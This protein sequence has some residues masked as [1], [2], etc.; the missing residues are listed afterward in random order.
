MSI[1]A[2]SAA[3]ADGNNDTIVSSADAGTLALAND[4]DAIDDL[5]GNYSDS[6]G[7]AV[8][9]DAKSVAAGKN[10]GNDLLSADND[11][12][13]NILTAAPKTYYV[14]ASAASGG[15]GTET[16]P[17]QTLNAALNKA[18]NGDTIMIAA[19]EYKGTDNTGLSI[20]RNLNFIK[21]GESEAIF[22]AEG[23]RRIWT[24]MDDSINI[25]GLTFKNGI[26][27]EGGAIY[28][29]G[30]NVT[31]CTFTGNNATGDS[32]SAGGAIYCLFYTNVTNCNFTGNTAQYRGGA[33]YFMRGGNVSD[34]TFT[35]NTANWWGGAIRLETAD[36]TKGTVINCA[37][38]NN[39]AQ[40]GKVISSSGVLE[41][42][43]NN[44][45]GSND[46]DWNELIN[47]GGIPSTYAVLNGSA[48]SETIKPG[49]NAK[50]NYTFYMNG[51]ANVLSIPSR[52]I[53]LSATG[54]HLDDDTGYL[55]N[56]E[57]STEFSSDALGEFEITATV[58]NQEVKLTETVAATVWYVNATAA[59]GGDGKSQA[60]PFQ[61]L[62]EALDVAEDY[63]TIMIAAGTYT[64]T[65]NIGLSINKKLSF[66]KYGAGEAIFDAQGQDRFWLVQFGVET[67]NINC[68][69][70][71]NGKS[72][73][74]G[75]IRFNNKL[76]NS[77]I[78]ATFINNTAT[79]YAGA[80][81]LSGGADNVNISGEFINNTAETSS[82]GA[83]Y[84]GGQ[85]TNVNICGEFRNNTAETNGGA[86]YCYD[87]VCNSIINST[88]KNNK[89][90]GNGRGGAISFNKNANHDNVNIYGEFMNNEAF[91]GAGTYFN[92]QLSNSNINAVFIN[93]TASS[94]GANLFMRTLTNVNITGDFIN[95]TATGS[96]EEGGGANYFNNA[97]TD[98]SISGNF[99]G[100]RA[101]GSADNDGG[102][103]NYFLQASTNVDITGKFIN[104][105][106]KNV[107]YFSNA[108]TGNEIHDSIFINNDVSKIINVVSGEVAA[109]D[110]WFGNNFTNRNNMPANAGIY[111]DN[112]LFLYGT[113]NT[114]E[115]NLGENSTIK[116]ELW[117]RGS[118]G[119]V[120]K[121]EGP[122]DIQLDLTQTLGELDKNAASLGEEITYTAENEG[123]GNVTATFETASYTLK[124]INIKPKT[125][126]SINL[127]NETMNL[128]VGDETPA[129][130][131]L[132]PPVGNLTY[133]SSDESVVTVENGVIKAVG[134]GTA[135]VTVSFNGTD[136]Y[137]PSERNISV[138]VS[139]NEAVWYYILQDVRRELDGAS[140]L[141]PFG[142]YNC[143]VVN[144]T[145]Q[146]L[147]K[148]LNVTIKLDD[149][150]TL[151]ST[152]G[153]DGIFEVDVNG[154]TPKFYTVTFSSYGYTSAVA[155]VLIT[156]K[157][158]SIALENET[159]ALKVN[160]N[161]SSGATLNPDEAGNL[162]Y[163]SS[164]ST[165]AIVENG[166]IK[167]LAKGTTNIT[168]SFAGDDEYAAA[169][170]RIIEVTVALNDASVT[171]N[172]TLDLL[173]GDEF[174]LITETVP[175]GLDVNFTST[176]SSVV[177][178]DADGKV[179]A[180]GNGTATIVVSV[181]DDKVY[182]IN[183]T[184]VAVTVKI[185]TE[186]NITNSSVE[187]YVGGNGDIT[188]AN[189]IPTEAGSLK[190]SSNDTSV[191]WVSTS[192]NFQTNSEGTAL[193]TVSFAGDENY[194]AAENKTITVT[195][196]KYPTEIILANATMDLNV[197]DE[198]PSG[199]TLEP[200]WAGELN[201]TSSN[202]SVVIVRNGM[203]KAV[204]EGTANVTV[205]FAGN[206][207][208]ADA[209]NK[210]ISVTVSL[211]DASVSVNND[212]LD[213]FVDDNF[214]IVATTVPANLN[215][216]YVPDNSGVV[217][218]DEKGIVTAL[219]EGTTSI[220]VRV[221]GDG[222]YAENS[223]AV[224]VTV[225]KIP[226][227]LNV[228]VNYPQA[229][230][231]LR[232]FLVTG[233]VIN[234]GTETRVKK[235]SVDIYLNNEFKLTVN[236][237]NESSFRC[238][239][240]PL[241][242]GTY[243]LYAEYY[244]KTGKFNKSYWI[245]RY[246]ITP[247]NTT[248]DVDG[249]SIELFVDD[250]AKIVAVLSPSEAGNL[251]YSSNDT[252]VASVDEYGNV[253]AV[254]AGTA[255]ITV[256]FAGNKNY[257]AAEN[258]T[259]AVTVSKIPTEIIAE[260]ATVEMNV[261][262]EVALVVSLMPSGA[263]ELD[264]TSSDVSVVTVNG[265]GELTAVGEGS[266]NI[267]VSFMGNDKYAAAENKTIT[268]S[269]Y[270]IAT[271]ILI[272]NKTFDLIVRD[273]VVTGAALLPSEAGNLTYV[274]SNELVAKVVDSMIVAV[275]E[276]N[277]TITVSFAG[278]NKYVA[279]ESKTI[280][281][282]VKKTDSTIDIEPKVVELIVGQEATVTVVLPNDATGVVL[283]DVKGKKYYGDV[284]NGNAT[285]KLVG[286]TGGNYT[287]DVVYPG[288]DK[289]SNAS[290]SVDVKVAWLT[291]PEIN[292]T[293]PEVKVGEVAK[294]IVELPKDATGIFAVH[295]D[296]K[297]VAVS[298]ASAGPFELPL[299]EF[300]AG[301]H[302][303]YVF[304]SGNEKYYE[305][306]VYRMFAV[307][308][309]S[310]N[311]TANSVEIFEGE[312]ATVV[313]SVDANATGTVLIDVAGNKY[314][315]VVENGT[316]SVN[317]TGLD[318][319][320]YTALITYM[321]DDKYVEATG[322]VNVKVAKRI[323][324]EGGI[325]V[326][327]VN[328]GEVAKVIA[329]LPEDATG[330]V[331]VVVDGENVTEVPVSGGTVEVPLGELSSG[332]HSVVVMYF[333][334]EK[335]DFCFDFKNFTVA[336]LTTNI[337]AEP[338]EIVEG[339]TATVVV[340]VD[341]N[342]TGVVLVDVNGIKY[343]ADVDAGKA[344]VNVSGLAAGNYTADVTYLGD[345]IFDSNSTAVEITVADYVKMNTTISSDVVVDGNRISLKVDVNENATGLVSVVINEKVIYLPVK[346]GKAKYD[347]I[348][349]NGFY[350]AF[351]TY[352]GDDNFNT[353]STVETFMVFNV[354]PVVS[355]F[356]N[357]SVVGT[358]ISAVLKDINGNPI[359]DANVTY[360]INGEESN[361]TTDSNG[362]LV[363][364]ASSNSVV[365]LKY[366]G[367]NLTL[368]ANFT[369][370][371]KDLVPVRVATVINSEDYETY[372]IDFDAGERGNYFKVK[373]VDVNG[374]P[375]ANKPVKI[376]FNGKVYN[377][378]TDASG[379]AK[380]QINLKQAGKY[381]FATAFLG[382]DEYT[383]TFVVNLITVNLKKTSISASAK[384][385]KASAKTKSYTV[386]LKT[387]KGSSIDGKTYL[388]AGKKITMK[389][390]GK[391]YTAKTN[392][393]GQATF[394]LS[395][396]KKGNFQ[397]TIKFAGDKMYASS[398]K[399]V[400][401][402][403]K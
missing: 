132:E 402:T 294:V 167:A 343:Y 13:G 322:N 185:P 171:V 10:N 201:Y 345:S 395:I 162:T 212:T 36:N 253:T 309:L 177:A 337:S 193:I 110:N 359:A 328:V 341:A 69:T 42:V 51:T 7:N 336:K 383:G 244:D 75:A 226:T 48:D 82:G 387:D 375:L 382:D 188:W 355:E 92:G 396:S 160:G 129:G 24:V 403:I 143:L 165:V 59:P 142:V 344:S 316:A 242:A 186:I 397:S 229:Y 195:V 137:A 378:T 364:S 74:G 386:T 73:W 264:F 106:G 18:E 307:E 353:N 288:D 210:T 318:A 367:D 68:L 380:L 203:I 179:T 29:R 306:G 1:S 152:V 334:N 3:D 293:V 283:V 329:E 230:D 228:T 158:T 93:N 287:A 117:T 168:V 302:T 266:A 323:V 108:D 286:L 52:P 84:F 269:V 370:T 19:G 321:G 157:P 175:A 58:D 365:E 265:I 136:V 47:K 153:D 251:S 224:A 325:H 43:D 376:G 50:L 194:A 121:Y 354:E 374:N 98:V 173:V 379:W 178:V 257:A 291:R 263:G 220:I 169:Q 91:Y 258:K 23:Q 126:T 159:L 231:P 281:V 314:Y 64:G 115:I 280:D 208:I 33:M 372:A 111:L 260:N 363:I 62:K 392:D 140:L 279:A 299:G 134:E 259:V 99:I 16:A 199:A 312:T 60:T 71:K 320:N 394:K 202:E 53:E 315:G 41:S 326:S 342:A 393:K 262:D 77:V 90:K 362:T 176:D 9:N 214:T 102:A 70:F 305:N 146:P 49:Y 223:T 215:V 218:I 8:E 351:I 94:G 273:N 122:I 131:T 233:Q 89:A 145:D 278:D 184:S 350:L 2:V 189:L 198:V 282:S 285:V 144:S 130:A 21:Y 216:T 155:T 313:V 28:M 227:K 100:N 63:D 65:K 96:G 44:W 107:M 398:S 138:T 135:N 95:N 26:N 348:L 390:N 67:I 361:T 156:K 205:S 304:Y 240:G 249:S 39:S 261:S 303:I 6:D 360:T 252:T 182:A 213:L 78:N 346:E 284:E 170:Y 120:S 371:I 381:T 206:Y 391:T 56:G 124:I 72:N 377:K 109:N 356:S 331:Y 276:G 154:I 217:S 207:V 246:T 166:E 30:G 164:N 133:K 237:D 180:V 310:T 17:F 241:D 79:N 101:E 83:I 38:V 103:A 335:Y 5:D 25:I 232:N 347:A 37:F 113:C 128:K 54:G 104:N 57:F 332:N 275:G 221:G 399:S 116:F 181:G 272:E 12:N 66:E 274:S 298:S 20:W 311:V 401:I 317:V 148:G 352:V 191:M 80:L 139:L 330:K 339:E 250:C 61:T 141:L 255:T 268:V 271:E 163:T 358:D 385:Y 22:D 245:E 235:G 248:I 86:I 349:D 225:S 400:K 239:L 290:G 357:I 119:F 149:A 27:R 219:K 40:Y 296:S 209:E 254:G 172:D 97:I 267:T 277:A 81:Y 292:I 31:N 196:I 105:T 222:V 301:N 211:N 368:P 333:G 295:V 238:D 388:S 197:N 174:T 373:L 161:V 200:S 187:L 118:G 85:L 324:P 256:S 87:V 300:S 147:P 236:V 366:L 247:A 327:D 308:K 125:P 11:E 76:Y 340:S 4:V 88:F 114:Y 192:G 297:I 243:E 190:Y 389:I 35:G 369:L 319:G 270:K 55:V 234:V 183:T 150:Y 15:T 14:N 32:T 384:S 151:N 338:V 123:M 34:C 127:T 46:P 289:Y 204:G 112:W 45:W